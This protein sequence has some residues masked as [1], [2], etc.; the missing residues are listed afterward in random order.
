MDSSIVSDSSCLSM[1]E[2]PVWIV[3]NSA[4]PLP[5]LP[6]IELIDMDAVTCSSRC[7]HSQLSSLLTLD[8]EVKCNLDWCSITS[9]VQGSNTSYV[10]MKVLNNTLKMVVSEDSPGLWEALHS[11]NI[12]SLSLQGFGDA[13]TARVKHG[14]LLNQSLSSL[15]QLETLTIHL[16]TYD[17]IKPPPSLKYLN[18][19]SGTLLPSQL[20]ELMDTLHACT[21]TIDS[22]IEFGCA[23]SIYTDD[24][25]DEERIQ[26]IALEE[27]TPIVHELETLKNVAVNRFR[28]LD[29]TRK[30]RWLGEDVDVSCWFVR[31]N[32]DIDDDKQ[33][34]DNF[35]D[36]LYTEFVRWMHKHHTSNINATS[37]YSSLDIRSKQ[38][39]RLQHMILL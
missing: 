18:I 20:R 16:R 11:L 23:M 28:I 29:R 9:S 7:L 15:T 36:K 10:Y 3:L 27:Y 12:K 31:S 32:G 2:H 34:D 17:V 4:A 38:S 6:C 5:A 33:N 8:H 30:N 24:N 13:T 26:Q 37:D 22:R 35:K 14:E 25:H 19:Y 21:Q 1:S 39:I